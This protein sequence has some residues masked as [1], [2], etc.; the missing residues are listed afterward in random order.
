MKITRLILLILL[1]FCFAC[2]NGEGDGAEQSDHD[3]QTEDRVLKAITDL[4]EYHDAEA[5]VNAV[6]GGKQSLSMI[7]Y[8]PDEETDQWIIQVGYN[9]EAWFEPY[10][11]FY[12][13]EE[14]LEVFIEDI[15]EGDVIPIETW[16]QRELNR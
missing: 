11:N 5:H 15:I 6:T 7:I 2:N 10:Y 1:P 3:I 14:T 13:D 9:Q 8:P 16:R 12:V 4:P